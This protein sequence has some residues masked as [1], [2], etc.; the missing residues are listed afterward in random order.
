MIM[1]KVILFLTALLPITTVTTFLSPSRF[2]YEAYLAV[3]S[4]SYVVFLI[5][6]S[7]SVR[8]TVTL[9]F[10]LWVCINAGNAIGILNILIDPISHYGFLVF[11][12]AALALYYLMSTAS[13][14]NIVFFLQLL[15]GLAVLEAILVVA[16]SN[17]GFPT[18]EVLESSIYVDDRGYLGFIFP[19]LFS[20]AVR[21]GTG[22][23]EHFNGVAALFALLF[24][25]AGGF[26]L[27]QRKLNRFLLVLIIFL[28]IF[29]SYSRGALIGAFVGTMF[30][31][32]YCFAKDRKRT[33]KIMVICSIFV[34]VFMGVE[35]LDTYFESTQNL[36]S[37]QMVWDV[38]WTYALENPG[39]LLFGFGFEFFSSFLQSTYT[40]SG[41][42]SLH[43]A[44]L[45]LLLELGILGFFLFFTFVF[46]LAGR[47]VASRNPVAISLMGGSIAFLIH[48]LFD[49]SLFRYNGVLM[50]A[51]AGIAENLVLTKGDEL[52]Y[53]WKPEVP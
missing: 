3:L 35:I 21:C 28:G 17:L 53:W 19:S 24:P 5:W 1:K 31:Y 44:L 15:F 33:L 40:A 41:L 11:P 34:L 51:F 47:A 49:N 26:W 25:V 18:F 32:F 13:S 39:N 46:K 4:I 9:V 48:Q 20:K 8:M 2:N 29:F 10:L 43:S 50:I 37:R 27:T 45:Q 42:F 16:Q 12:F 38:A 6:K 30:V 52:S 22:T 36:T 23:Y 14:S 7:G